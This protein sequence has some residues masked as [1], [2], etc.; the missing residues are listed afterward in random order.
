[1]GGFG[2]GSK[3]TV[4]PAPVTKTQ[5]ALQK[6]QLTLGEAQLESIKQQTELQTKIFDEVFGDKSVLEVQIDQLRDELTFDQLERSK[7]LAPLEEELFNLQFD[8]I[9]NPGANDEQIAQIEEAIQ[10]AQISGE[11]DIDRITGDAIKQV[12]DVLAPSRGL[13]PT[14][15]PIIDR[16]AEIAKRGIDLK[17]DLTKKLAETSANAKLNFPFAVSQFQAG[18]AGIGAGIA[19][20]AQ[21]FQQQLSNSAFL[22]RI[23]AVNTTGSLGLGLASIGANSSGLFN[24]NTGSTTTTSSSGLGFGGVGSILSGV[25]SLAPFFSP[26][27]A[28]FGTQSTLA[29]WVAREV[30]GKD[31]PKWLQFREYLETKAPKW[32]YDF[33]LE[34]GE[35]IAEEIKDKPNI[36]T[37]IRGLMDRVLMDAYGSVQLY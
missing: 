19:E 32:F 21:Q 24:N 17:G 28:I 6:Q 9:K 14:D 20:A 13:R 18:A 16:G 35:A 23:S 2:G 15:S 30:F 3:T 34:N 8:A 25:G 33:Y 31:N 5:L 12:R 7:R 36:K 29:C 22:N 4:T 27:G 1:M 26:A 10:A 11:A 37:E